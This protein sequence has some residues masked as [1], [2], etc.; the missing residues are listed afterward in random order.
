LIV[1]PQIVAAF[2]NVA[3]RPIEN[4]G[5]GLFGAVQFKNLRVGQKAIEDGCGGRQSSR[6]TP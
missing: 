1:T 5:L 2:W 3:T 4:N 6:D